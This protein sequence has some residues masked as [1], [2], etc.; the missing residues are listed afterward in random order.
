MGDVGKAASVSRFA[1]SRAAQEAV[2]TQFN[3]PEPR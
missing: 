3:P 2:F 1:R